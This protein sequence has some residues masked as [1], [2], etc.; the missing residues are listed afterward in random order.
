MAPARTVA[1]WRLAAGVGGLGAEVSDGESARDVKRNWLEG[2]QAGLSIRGRMKPE[3][4]QRGTSGV[5]RPSAAVRN[6]VFRRGKPTRE[7]YLVKFA[8]WAVVVGF[9][10]LVAFVLWGLAT[11]EPSQNRWNSGD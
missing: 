9:V 7:L 10:L 3:N 6:G 8:F 5:E 1:A 11:H 4:V 2:F